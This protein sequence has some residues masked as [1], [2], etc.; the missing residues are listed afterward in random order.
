MKC[1]KDTEMDRSYLEVFEGRPFLG[2]YSEYS[3]VPFS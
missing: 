3:L 2:A 1:V